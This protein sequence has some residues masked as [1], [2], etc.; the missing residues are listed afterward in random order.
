MKRLNKIS[1]KLFLLLLPV[2][3]AV[4]CQK[5]DTLEQ[6][7]PERIFTPVGIKS[8]V[9]GSSVKIEWSRSL[10]SQSKDIKYTIEVS[11]DSSFSAIDYTV[12]TDTTNVTLSD[13]NLQ[14]N[15]SYVARVKASDN[16]SASPTP[17]SKW[18]LSPVFKL[19]GILYPVATGELKDKSAV[20]RWAAKTGLTKI[21]ITPQGGQPFDIALS[22]DDVTAKSKMITGLTSN[23]TYTAEIFAGT[24]SKGVTTFTTPAFSVIL[25]PTD[26]LAAAVDAAADGAIIGLNDGTYSTTDATG[27]YANIN[28]VQKAISI[29]SVSGDPAKVKVNFKEIDLKGSGAGLSVRGIEFDGTAG[30][31]SYFINFTGV[32]SDNE[33]A[34]FAPVTVENCKVHFTANCLIRGNRGAN[35]A[36]KI[37]QIKIDNSV[38]YDSGTGGY[39]YILLD[40]MEFKSLQITNS[41][42]YNSG[43]VLVSWATNLTVA[44]K[45]T[46]LIDQC[47]INGLG[48]GGTSRNYVLLDANTNNIDFAIQNSIVAN[49]PK[50]G[51]SIGGIALRAGT[52]GTVKFINNNYFNLNGG[53]PVA[54]LT[55]PDYVT[56]SNNKTVDLG[57]TNATTAFTLP[58]SSELRTASTTGGALGDPRWK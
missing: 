52:G 54:P 41:T 15:Q 9:T 40:K 20:L 49:T 5:D 42:F 19:Q 51:Q 27:A 47:T 7:N 4:S 24:V 17:E 13:D 38:I 3:V 34:N 36:Y 10:F 31:A 45:P 1:A 35:N 12:T 58:A 6:F 29:R 16:A 48:Y 55:F 39:N 56:R 8:T 33:T 30:N 57:W 50:A 11:K 44:Q 46:V 32:N 53:D 18:M 28:I 22:A 2:I 26:D 14:I 43:R 21:T 37:D 25:S 23:T